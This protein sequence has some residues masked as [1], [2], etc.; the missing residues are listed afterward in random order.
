MLSLP[1]RLLRHLAPEPVQVS[2]N[3]IVRSTFAA[4]IGM[5]AVTGFSSFML[6]AS[7]LPVVA[8]SMGASAVLT[9]ALPSSPLSQPWPLVGSHII[10]ASIG[11]AACLWISEPVLAAAVAVSLSIL[12]MFLTHTLHPPG[13]AAALLPVVLGDS[14]R[15]AGFAFVVAPV[16]VNVFV[17]LAVGMA[18]NILVFG[19]RYPAKPYEPENLIHDSDDPPSLDR[20][21]IT[22]GDLHQALVDLDIYLD[23][24]EEDLNRIY[25]MAGAQ[26]YRRRMGE[27]TCQD[28]MSRDLV[29]LRLDTDV[30]EAWSLLRHHKLKALPV[31]DE[32]RHVIGI[33]TL[34]DV[35]KPVDLKTY[36]GF[37][38]KLITFIRRALPV[39]SKGPRSV[40]D[41]MVRPV[42]TVDS[43]MHITEVVPLLSDAGYHNLP[44]VDRDY[45]LV[46]MIT[47]SDLIA[48]LYNGSLQTQGETDAALQ[49]VFTTPLRSPVNI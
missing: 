34:V 6:P 27:I 25:R 9:F 46:G 3:E 23:V 35:L 12:V 2:G 19:R 22:H 48:A 32:A 11:V 15:E 5:L 21:G 49:K 43:D 10:S 41:I 7:A 20:I 4:F 47:Q 8:A 44:V 1:R 45:R 16:A 13:G 42:L 37:D 30:E 18:I 24:S 36:R 39:S 33:L 26:A 29:T 17:L 31:I 14:V 40:G 38:E 28:I